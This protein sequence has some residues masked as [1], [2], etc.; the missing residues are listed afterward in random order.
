VSRYIVTPD[1]HFLQISDGRVLQHK[2]SGQH[3]V[4]E[5][6]SVKDVVWYVRLGIWLELSER[7]WKLLKLVEFEE[8]IRSVRCND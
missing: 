3:D 2:A 5:A 1:T 6:H 8:E 7:D 4:T